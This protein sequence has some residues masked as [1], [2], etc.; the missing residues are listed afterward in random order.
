M[1]T[2]YKLL[3]IVASMATVAQAAPITPTKALSEA[4]QF[5]QA[6][7]AKGVMRAPQRAS[8]M[9]LAYTGDK[10]TYYAFNRGAGAGYV[11]VAGDDCSPTILGYS[12]KGDF[13][14]DNMPANMK[15]WLKGYEQQVAASAALGIKYEA[16]AKADDRKQVAQMLTSQWGQ[17]APYNIMCPT[18]ST[19]TGNAVTGCV[20]TAMSQVARYHQWPAKASGT[21]NATYNG[22]AVASID[23]SN[24]TFEWDKMLDKY[25]SATG[26]ST[27]GTTEQRN[28]VALLMR[29][30]GY[31]VNMSYTD[32]TSSANSYRIAQALV[33]NFSYDKATHT[34]ARAWWSD[35]EWD[36][37]IYNEVANG[38]PVL[39]CGVTK[40]NEG[41]E[42]VCDGYAGNG[43]YHFNWGWN[44]LSDDNFLLSALNPK[45]QGTGGSSRQYAFDY[46]QNV[47]IG[48]Q[49]PVE[50]SDY[51][52]VMGQE[53]DFTYD[54]ANNMFNSNFAN[55][56]VT[57]IDGIFGLKVVNQSTL[58]TTYVTLVSGNLGPNKYYPKMK[59]DA[60]TYA[61]GLY[62]LTLAFSTDNGKTW[63]DGRNHTT[64]NTVLYMV[65]ENGERSYYTTAEYASLTVFTAPESLKVTNLDTDN[66]FNL[67][68]DVIGLSIKINDVN[69]H[70]LTGYQLTVE[71]DGA[72][73]ATPI[74]TTAD[75]AKYDGNVITLEGNYATS[76]LGITEPGTYTITI[77]AYKDNQAIVITPVDNASVTF[78]AKKNTTGITEAQA[79]AKV[80]LSKVYNLQG[81]CVAEHNGEA[82]LSGLPSGAYI[83]SSTLSDGTTKVAKTIVR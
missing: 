45:V 83:V 70:K 2:K 27:S 64:Y 35:A 53:K 25:S 5:C 20:A 18:S 77:S 65:V 75:E 6:Q 54:A 78:E 46:K 31:S 63:I 57:S 58:D 51:V 42:F 37:I 12:S 33:N 67:S 80:T 41:H 52:L 66:K 21:G 39:Y 44:G 29:D 4:Q 59:A 47:V 76:D 73:V 23:M 11:I 71:R 28:A 38:R 62:K 34:E 50:G 13:D 81:I 49:K 9:K 8:E 15:A 56:S 79:A 32:T 55:Y 24:D 10:A 43:Y 72:T 61:D 22:K 48:T 26:T 60:S 74:F 14:Y 16:P 69:G 30:M 82:I 36:D 19:G 3:A 1:K 17:R 40:V 7:E 68:N